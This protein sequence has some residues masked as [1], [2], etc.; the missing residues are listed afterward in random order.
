MA[1]TSGTLE[2]ARPR[3]GR[4]SDRD[5]PPRDRVVAVVIERADKTCGIVGPGS[6]E[7]RSSLRAA[8]RAV[9]DLEPRVVWR[10]TTRGV[11]VAVALNAYASPF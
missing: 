4:R 1:Q 7:S 11:W 10:E 3:R 9:E 8:K 5:A 2:L 6:G